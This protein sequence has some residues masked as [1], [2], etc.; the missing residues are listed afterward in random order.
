MEPL[1]E[2]PTPRQL[3]GTVMVL[4]SGA[5]LRLQVDRAQ[6]GMSASDSSVRATEAAAM[7][8]A[9][10]E[11][12]SNSQSEQLQ[13][14]FLALL[15]QKRDYEQS[16]AGLREH[17][18]RAIKLRRRDDL[19]ALHALRD[20]TAQVSSRVTQR[21][22]ELQ[23][24]IEDILASP[25]TDPAR[26]DLLTGHALGAAPFPVQLERRLAERRREARDVVGPADEAPRSDRR[27]RLSSVLGNNVTLTGPTVICRLEAR[28]NGLIGLNLD[29][30][31]AVRLVDAAGV[32]QQ[33]H[34]QQDGSMT[35][36]PPHA[37]AQ[38]LI[39]SPP[40][41]AIALHRSA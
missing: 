14:H 23:R 28:E 2:Q 39:D 8:D 36:E 19:P 13:Q 12:L 30:N 7:F 15:E 31:H 22:G 1:S 10:S 9:L 20:R 41:Y 5:L 11:R 37:D 38:L 33:L 29:A 27:S 24:L 35:F 34:S 32:V 6:F 16:T 40:G 3:L 17:V 26:R 18:H 4:G 25:V 21:L